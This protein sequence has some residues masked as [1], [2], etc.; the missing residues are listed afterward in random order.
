MLF[1]SAPK[2]VGEYGGGQFTFFYLKELG[3]DFDAQGLAEAA[4]EDFDTARKALE[5]MG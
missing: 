1:R 3:G 2:G 5:S 4:D